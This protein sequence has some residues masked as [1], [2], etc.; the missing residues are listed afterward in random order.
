MHTISPHKCFPE[1]PCLHCLRILIMFWLFKDLVVI[2][3]EI[4]SWLFK[5][6]INSGLTQFEHAQLNS[7]KWPKGWE[8]QIALNEF[9]L[10]KQLIKFLCTYWPLLFCQIFKKFLQW[11]QSYED[12]SFFR[13]KWFICRKQTFFLKKIINII[14]ICLL[15][16]F[17]LQNFKKILRANLEL[18]GCTIFGS[19]IPQFAL[20]K[21]FWYKPLLLL[22]FT[23]RPFSLDKN[24]KKFLQR[25]QSYEDAQFLGLE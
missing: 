7:K 14:F 22:S 5:D 6:P 21:R 20:S 23:Y 4:M 8:D 15:A 10:E 13:P 3:K 25:I 11:I 18:W 2:I 24:L 12:A 9:F 19:K 17:I 16:P 1:K